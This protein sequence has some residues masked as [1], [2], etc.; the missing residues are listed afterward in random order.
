MVAHSYPVSRW[1]KAVS[2]LGIRLVALP[3]CWKIMA[4][5]GEVTCSKWATM[6]SI[7][8]ALIS[9]MKWDLM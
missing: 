6:V 7:A 5:R 3:I 2:P 8:P 4:D 1:P 9:L